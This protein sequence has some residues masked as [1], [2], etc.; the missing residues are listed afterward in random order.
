MP[1]PP[2]SSISG[3]RLDSAAVTFMLVRNRPIAG[4]PEL[5]GLVRLGAERLHDAMAGERLGADVRQLLERLLAAPRRPPHALA[6]PDR[7]DT[8]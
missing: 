8:R 3:G 6:E 1:T 5:L 4:A 7:A 2:S